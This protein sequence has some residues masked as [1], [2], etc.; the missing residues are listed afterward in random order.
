MQGSQRCARAFCESPEGM[1]REGPRF[2][3]VE[4]DVQTAAGHVYIWAVILPYDQSRACPVASEQ[5]CQ[6]LRIQAD[7]A[8]SRPKLSGRTDDIDI[9]ICPKN[10]NYRPAARIKRTG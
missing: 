9:D 4:Y 2:A 1:R 10:Y 3:S 8:R 7:V 5:M 6:I